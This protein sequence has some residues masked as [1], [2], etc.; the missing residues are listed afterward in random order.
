MSRA[1]PLHA[2][3]PT[4]R[5]QNPAHNQLFP[6]E[7]V[8]SSHRPTCTNLRKS[9]SD[10]AVTSAQTVSSPPTIP[11]K[12]SAT[13]GATGP[14]CTDW[15][16]SNRTC[17]DWGKEMDNK[18]VRIHSKGLLQDWAYNRDLYRTGQSKRPQQ[19]QVQESNCKGSRPE[20]EI[21]AGRGPNQGPSCEQ[22]PAKEIHWNRSKPVTF[23]RAA[24]N[25]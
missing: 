17:T 24:L 5:Q 13:P 14:T 4:T 7:S 10:Q 12:A 3:T 1:S 8:T 23:A 9:T 2:T 15:R 20:L 16:K 18:S 25:R 11:P 21:S 6:M 19:E 22:E